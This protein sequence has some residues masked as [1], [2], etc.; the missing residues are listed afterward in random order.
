[1]PTTPPKPR[2]RGVLHQWAAVVFAVL[3]AL[4]IVFTEGAKAVT[5]VSIYA[6]AVVAL[7]TT[8]AVYHRITWATA[9]ARRWMRRLDHSMIYVLIAGTYTPFAL[10]ALE[11]AWATVM[12]AVVWAGAAAGIV[13]QLLWP[14]HPKWLSALLYV[15]LGW[16][17]LVA[18]PQLA[19]E[20]GV[21]GVALVLS[22]G[23]L[24]T[25]GA[26]V[27]ARQRPDPAPR[28]FGYHEVFHLLVIAAAVLHFAAIAFVVVPLQG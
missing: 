4:L 8:S 26:V 12:L 25:I 16:V 10:L 5:A 6:A 22:G 14:D 17:A 11:G 23:V 2:L 9:A 19:R 13:T 3:G 27:Y 7:F 18:S 21:S 15:G 20:L 28:T 24:Y 1:M